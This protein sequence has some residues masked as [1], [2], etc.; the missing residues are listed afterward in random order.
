MNFNQAEKKVFKCDTCDGEPQCV[1][2]CDM[3]AVD[4]VSPTKES[5]NRKRDAA[6]KF[7][8]A[9]KLGATVQYEG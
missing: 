9:K 4:F 2:F 7:S 6:Y 3:K 1:R 8:E 5:L